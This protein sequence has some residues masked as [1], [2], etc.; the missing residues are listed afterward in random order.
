MSKKVV[1]QRHRNWCFTSYEEWLN[2]VK[3]SYIVVGDETCPTTKKKHL[4]G[5]VEFTEG[6]CK[7]QVQ[8]RIGDPKAHCEP[9]EGTAQQAANYCKKE[10]ILF[11]HGIMTNQGA[12]TD[13]QLIKDEMLNGR[14]DIRDMLEKDMLNNFQQL[15]FAE[16]LVKYR[17]K[18]ERDLPEIFWW[19]GATGT[20]KTYSVYLKEGYDNLHRMEPTYEW[21]DGYVGQDAVLFDDFRGNITLSLI[22]QLTDR[23]PLS[24]KVKGGFA[25]WRPKRIYI[26]S[27]RSPEECYKGCTEDIGQLFRRLTEVKEFV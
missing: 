1:E 19:F 27:S 20:K 6:I 10:K 24:V 12:R 15:S 14:G 18:T 11:E 26:T 2:P 3:Y 9:R 22:L 23:Y 4:Q 8:A 7:T 13:L 5:Y 21:Y 17:R 25:D 16:K